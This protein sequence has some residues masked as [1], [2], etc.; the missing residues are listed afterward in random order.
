VRA[1][2][3]NEKFKEDTDPIKDM[4]IGYSARTL[5]SKSWKILEFIGSKEE[6]GASLTE[7][8]RFIWTKLDG[9][10]EK[11][12]WE[13]SPAYDPYRS[14][15]INKG[16]GLRKTRGHWNTQLFGGFHYH[17]GLLHKYCN[18]NKNRKW[19]LKRMPQPKEKMYNWNQ[20]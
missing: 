4:G 13:K 16:A 20:R 11:S 9:Y 14:S 2:F 5:N 17:E 3:V 15:M 1:K 6:E 7:I 8:Q 10:S 19:V 18:K 12:F